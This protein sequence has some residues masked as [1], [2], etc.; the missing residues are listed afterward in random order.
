MA[1][2]VADVRNLSIS[3]P[4]TGASRINAVRDVSF[5]V[6]QGEILGVVG[7][8]GSG[9]S[10]TMRSLVGL[11]GPAA[12]T[13]SDLHEV[14]GQDTRSFSEKAWRN[15][16][17]R[18]VGLVLQDALVSLDPL[19]NVGNE[20]VEAV[21]AHGGISAR[22][23]HIRAL[24][25]MADVGIPSP[26]I[27]ARLYSHQLSGGLRQR[28]LIA[29][30]I[31]A[32]PSLII[33]DEPTTALDVRVQAQILTLL[34]T[35]VHRGAGLIIISHDIGVIGRISDRTIV[36][37]NGEIVETGQTRELLDSPQD[38][39]TRRL[40]QAIPSGSSRG[41]RLSQPVV[42]DSHDRQPAAAVRLPARKIIAEDVVIDVKGVS[43]SYSLPS[44]GTRYAVNDVSFR[45]RRGETI[46][47]V[48]ESGSGKSSIAKMI[49]GLL[50]PDDGTILLEGQSWSDVPEKHR[51]K[52]RAAI[53]IV[54]QDTLGVF[55]PRYTVEQ[56]IREAIEETLSIERSAIIP[57]IHKLIDWVG[58]PSRHLE[59]SLRDL[60]GG[61]RQRVAIARALATRPRLMV[62][63]EPVSALD[64]SIQAQILD[65]LWD[66]QS[67]ASLSYLFI[68][69]DLGV[70][71]HLSDHVIVMR[72]GR[73]VESGSATDIFENPRHPYTAELL[74]AV[75]DK[76]IGF[77]QDQRHAP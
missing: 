39:Y 25:L 7:E 67:E 62:C 74:A 52:R 22:D 72:D 1:P 20:I 41:Y 26:E 56:S 2:L 15:L 29:S 45:I 6:R 4:G 18:S 75:P 11:Q 34:K 9:K 53:Q 63:D 69:H 33:A 48:G 19:R 77:F 38:P 54:T 50:P 51:R 57:E 24:K 17:G 42:T 59:K 65:L 8:S 31:A 13:D 32:E 21:R 44:G 70:V 76:R 47:L 43:K 58:L 5:T 3:F 61:E 28:A 10:V 68:S 12:R 23:A 16:R 27:Y 46:G 73:I 37:R 64:L 55:D 40:L 35:L 36:M 49:M 71:H 14:M 30:A 66:L 60:S